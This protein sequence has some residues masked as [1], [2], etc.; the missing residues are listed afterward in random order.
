MG[1]EVLKGV[2]PSASRSS[3][4]EGAGGGLL[5]VEFGYGS[6]VGDVVGEYSSTDI[7]SEWFFIFHLLHA[8]PMI[9]YVG[10]TLLW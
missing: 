3:W 9:F 5:G 6:A 4:G 1:R 8:P 2:T 10:A 7:H